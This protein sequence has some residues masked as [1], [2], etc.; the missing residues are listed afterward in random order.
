VIRPPAAAIRFGG[1]TQADGMRIVDSADPAVLQ[2]L[3]AHARSR[4]VTVARLLSVAPNSS[5]PI[6]LQLVGQ[7]RRLVSGGQLIAG[8]VLPSVRCLARALDV[9]PMTVSKA[10]SLLAAEGLLTR[11]R[12]LAMAVAERCG[13][14]PDAP[15]D[16]DLL[17]PTL[18]RAVREALEL[19][20]PPGRALTLFKQILSERQSG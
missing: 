10:F 19:R 15:R 18:E 12:G 9:N 6:Y 20:L 4:E 11:R 17:R 16:I 7:V 1:C 5:E 2:W 3:H 13:H 14:G 8:D